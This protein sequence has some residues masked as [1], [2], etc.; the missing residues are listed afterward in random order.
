MTFKAP[1]YYTTLLCN[2]F[3]QIRF[4][5][6]CVG[7]GLCVC[8]CVC[9][10]VRLCVCVCVC[11]CVRVCVCVCVCACVCVCVCHHQYVEKLDLVGLVSITDDGTRDKKLDAA[12]F[13]VCLKDK[14]IKLTVCNENHQSSF[15]SAPSPMHIT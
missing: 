2:Y 5:L 10:C 13:I 1:K 3:L 4:Y 12:R 6:K 15:M 7:V 14:S 11:L 9:V 8:V